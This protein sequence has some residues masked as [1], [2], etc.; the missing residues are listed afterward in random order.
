[1]A[2]P[3]DVAKRS[4]IKVLCWQTYLNA[5]IASK[6]ISGVLATRELASLSPET[7]LGHALERVSLISE[8]VPT[9]SCPL[10]FPSPSPD[11]DG[12]RVEGRAILK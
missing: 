6:G 5:P 9:Q 8:I 11:P 3:A 12:G 2:T 7:L 1:V 4:Y 10:P